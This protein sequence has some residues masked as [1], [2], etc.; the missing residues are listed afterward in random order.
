MAVLKMCKINICA[1]KK[2]EKDFGTF[3]IKGLSGSS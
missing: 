2:D 1:M 3:A